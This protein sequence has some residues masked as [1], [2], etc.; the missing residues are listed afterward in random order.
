MSLLGRFEL[1][2]GLEDLLRILSNRLKHPQTWLLPL[3]FGLLQQAFLD[4]R[5]HALEP[6]P[7]TTTRRLTDGLD[8]LQ[9]TAADKDRKSSKE[10]LLFFIEQVVTP[11][12][13]IA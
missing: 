7:S 13:G 10:A 3:R 9:G 12:D 8:C 5:G 6:L 2:T 4:Q 1:S 11:G